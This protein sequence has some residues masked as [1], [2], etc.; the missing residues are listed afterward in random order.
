VATLPEVYDKQMHYITQP[1][2]LSRT[3]PKVVAAAPGWG[4]HTDEVLDEIGY[5]ADQIKSLHDNGV[6]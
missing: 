3:P 4:E 6:V 5:S 2:T 1:M